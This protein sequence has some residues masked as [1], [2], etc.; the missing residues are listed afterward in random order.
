MARYIR[1]VTFEVDTNVCTLCEVIVKENAWFRSRFKFVV[2]I[3][4]EP[5]KPY[6]TKGFELGIV[7]W[8]TE[9]NLIECS[10]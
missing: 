5:W 7:R 9:K 3:G 10:C 8:M 1:F 4:F 6:A 2:G